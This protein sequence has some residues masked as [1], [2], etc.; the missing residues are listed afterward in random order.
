MTDGFVG[1][2][3]ESFVRE[4]AM[5]TLRRDVNSKFVSKEDFDMAFKGIKPS[6]SNDTAKL[7]KKMEDYYLK[8]AK[9]GM[10]VGPVYTG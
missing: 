5:N 6:V 4:A 8:S 3:L 10:E 7:Y 1:A 2:D 9:A